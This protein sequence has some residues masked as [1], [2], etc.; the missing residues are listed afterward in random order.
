MAASNNK[1]E[2]LRNLLAGVDITFINDAYKN[3]FTAL[4]YACQQGHIEC[5]KLLLD[6]G[7]NIGA[8]A[9]KSGTV[10]PIKLLKKHN[11]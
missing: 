11:E 7:A 8:R 6:A 4:H 10:T 2:E 3:G 5:A 1:I 9:G